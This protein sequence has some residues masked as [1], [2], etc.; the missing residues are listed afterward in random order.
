MKTKIVFWV[1]NKP[2]QTFSYIY[3]GMKKAFE[4]LGWDVKFIGLVINL[5]LLNQNLITPIVFSL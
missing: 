4:R 1:E 5:F 3:A 2:Y